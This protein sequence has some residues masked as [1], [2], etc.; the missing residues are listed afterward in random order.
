MNCECGRELPFGGHRCQFCGKPFAGEEAE[1]PEIYFVKTRSMKT[2]IEELLGYKV[3]PLWQPWAS[4]VVTAQEG[5]P[6]FPIK[7]WET[8]SWETAY[9]GKVI[10][11]AAKNTSML[12][13]RNTWPFSEFDMNG[14]TFGALIGTVEIT[15]MVTAGE[16]VRNNMGDVK[17]RALGDFNPGRYCWRL[18]RPEK[19]ETPIPY[20]GQQGFVK[21]D[22]SRIIPGKQEVMNE[23]R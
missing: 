15:G 16:W 1:L 13:L 7:E 4:L 17:Q 11:H 21:F 9:R 3:L 2:E 8:R 14:L 19:F 23:L 12:M 10:I 6:E 20:K 22:P 5:H 18:M